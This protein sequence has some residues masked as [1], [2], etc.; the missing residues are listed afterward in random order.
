M[1]NGGNVDNLR[2]FSSLS[3]EEARE[4]GRK[5]GLA[6]VAKRQDEKEHCEYF[7]VIAKYIHKVVKRKDALIPEE[8]RVFYLNAGITASDRLLDMAI[9]LQQVLKALECRDTA[10]AT[11]WAK[12]RGRFNVNVN[13]EFGEDMTIEQW[14]QIIMAR[15]NE[16]LANDHKGTLAK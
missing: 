16:R 11:Y 4:K 7:D 13:V 5:G 15:K 14:Y 2:P 10:A 1:K 6:S 8:V 12:I 3:V 9:D